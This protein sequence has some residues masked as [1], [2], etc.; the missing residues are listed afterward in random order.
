MAEWGDAGAIAGAQPARR[1][2]TKSRAKKHGGRQTVGIYRLPPQ[3]HT[4]NRTHSEWVSCPGVVARTR[5]ARAPARR[6]RA[7]RRARWDWARW[8]A[9]CPAQR[10]RSGAHDR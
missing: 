3:Q 1:H 4:Q 8:V 6:A 2:R 10:G 5:A 7:R 9:G